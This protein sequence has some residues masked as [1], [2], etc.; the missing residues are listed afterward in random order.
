MLRGIDI[1]DLTKQLRLRPIEERVPV[2]A[3]AVSR[4]AEGVRMLGAVDCLE[5][6]FAFGD[7]LKMVAKHCARALR[8]Q[9]S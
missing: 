3:L 5:K 7:V 6:P 9:P 2:I 1:G 8:Q 4:N